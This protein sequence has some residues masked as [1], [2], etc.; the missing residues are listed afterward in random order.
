MAAPKN[1]NRFDGKAFWAAKTGSQTAGHDLDL[2][3]GSATYIPLKFWRPNFFFMG[4]K[5]SVLYEL[6]QGTFPAKLVKDK[7]RPVFSL[8]ELP[9]QIGFWICP[10]SSKKQFKSKNRRFIRERCSLS[11]TNYIMDRNSY[12]VEEI[13]LNIPQS[14]AYTLRFKGE[15]PTGC[16]IKNYQKGSRLTDDKPAG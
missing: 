4:A 1:K 2:V 12:L 7:T 3:L 5:D 15:V 9:H 16:I 8:A 13:K 10:C 14:V 6:S 11:H